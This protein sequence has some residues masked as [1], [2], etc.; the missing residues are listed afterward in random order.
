MS[1]FLQQQQQHHQIY[2]MSY[3][4]NKD[5]NDTNEEDNAKDEDDDDNDEIDKGGRKGHSFL[6]A[7]SKFMAQRGCERRNF[8]NTSSKLTNVGKFTTHK[9]K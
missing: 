9:G 3:E 2:S 7:T 5:T 6:T 1:S 4:T 8:L